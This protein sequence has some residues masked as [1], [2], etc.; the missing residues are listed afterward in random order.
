[1]R[2]DTSPGTA[3]VAEMTTLSCAATFSVFRST[4]TAWI[5]L[6]ETGRLLVPPKTESAVRTAAR[7]ASE[8][9][10]TSTPP[11]REKLAAAGKGGVALLREIRRHTA[12]PGR[13]PG[14]GMGFQP[15]WG[16]G[17]CPSPATICPI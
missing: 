17:V 13:E 3:T 2:I 14:G 10:F 1:M 8:R 16:D 7:I 12:R 4:L 5:T 6:G 15:L 11:V 9:D